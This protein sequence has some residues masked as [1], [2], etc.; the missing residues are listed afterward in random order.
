MTVRKLGRSLSDLTGQNRMPS[1]SAAPATGPISFAA[2]CSARVIC[3][4]SGKGGTGKSVFTSNL[5]TELALRGT[6]VLT[7][8]ADLGLAN[9]HL[10]LG[11]TP[12]RSLYHALTSN[13]PFRE[14]AERTRAGVWLVPGPSGVPELADL[15]PRDLAHLVGETA[16]FGSLFDL[17]LVD[18]AAGISRM[19]TAFLNAAR[20]IMV[21]TTPDLTAMTDAYATMKTTLRHNP[22]AVISIVVNRARTARQGWEIFQTLDGIA[23]RFMARRLCYAGYLPE[24]ETVRRSVAMKT[25]AVQMDPDS[26]VALRVRDIASVLIPPKQASGAHPPR[27]D[28]ST[29]QGA[30]R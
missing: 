3:V 14:I 23:G 27:E 7:V 22:A 17:V 6:R 4:T 30:E 8:D 26:A 13:L 9:L 29:G 18:T 11:L 19:T 21:V 5:S 10:L 12:R 16:R 20:E 24:D 2:S 1:P 15:S 25:P 28:H